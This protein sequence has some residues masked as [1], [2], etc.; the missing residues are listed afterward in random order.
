MLHSNVILKVRAFPSG[1]SVGYSLLGIAE[2]TKLFLDDGSAV[3][4]KQIGALISAAGG[5]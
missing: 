2:G 4:A 3:T 1:K 5:G